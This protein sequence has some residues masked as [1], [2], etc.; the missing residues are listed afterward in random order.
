MD[1]RA[2]SFSR[3]CHSSTIEAIDDRSSLLQL[4]LI[5][6]IFTKVCFSEIIGCNNRCWS[7]LAYIASDLKGEIVTKYNRRFV[8]DPALMHPDLVPLKSLFA[9]LA[10]RYLR[11]VCVPP[12]R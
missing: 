4:W 12:D 3:H 9:W 2:R 7:Q 11:Y 1:L 6:D 5:V 10:N 8:L